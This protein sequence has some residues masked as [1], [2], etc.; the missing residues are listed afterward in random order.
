MISGN[1]PAGLERSSEGKR[2][3]F[4]GEPAQSEC[5]DAGDANAYTPFVGA[6][7]SEAS[8]LGTRSGMEIL[9]MICDRLV[10]SQN[11]FKKRES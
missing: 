5:P 4:W 3:W 9:L 11:I 6:V 7:G 10:V 8:E 2:Q 1:A